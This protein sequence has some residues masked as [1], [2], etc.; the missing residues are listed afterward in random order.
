VRAIAEGLA[1]AD[2]RV[3]RVLA[4]P[5]E[6]HHVARRMFEA[7]GFRLMGVRDLGHKHAALLFFDISPSE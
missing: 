1:V 3:R 7:G 6:R 2:P 4:D 5:D